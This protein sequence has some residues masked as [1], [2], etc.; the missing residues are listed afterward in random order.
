MLM[1]HEERMLESWSCP[2]EMTP[3][4]RCQVERNWQPFVQEFGRRCECG[5]TVEDHDSNE[6]SR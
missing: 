3:L 6:R 4:L 5:L 1:H 2:C